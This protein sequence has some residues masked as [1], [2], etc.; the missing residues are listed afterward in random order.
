MVCAILGPANPKQF[1][2]S[3]LVSFLFFL[4]LALGGLFFV[5]I[6]YATQGGWGIVL[7][8]IWRDDLR[9]VPVMAVLFL[10]VLLGLH[11]LSRGPSPGQPSTMRCFAWKDR[12]YAQCPV[13]PIRAAVYFGIWS[14]IAIAYYRGSSGQAA[15]GAPGVSAVCAASPGPRSSSWRTQSFAAVGRIMS[16]TPH[17][18]S[19]TFGVDFFA[20]SWLPQMLPVGGGCGDAR[21]GGRGHAHQRLSTC[22]ARSGSPV[23]VHRVLGHIAVFSMWY[24]NLPEETIGTRRGWKDPG[25]P[26]SLFLMAGHFAAPFFYLMG[27]T[28]K[29]KGATLAAGGAWVLGMTCQ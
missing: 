24:G 16:L 2:F 20:G 21:R 9:D 12:H 10:P 4:S 3:W 22:T 19:T 13:L 1:F 6:Q 27:R 8:R 29:R 5:L 26:V 23:C 14:F 7:R 15:T 11:D 17:S 28:V 18:Y 25:Q